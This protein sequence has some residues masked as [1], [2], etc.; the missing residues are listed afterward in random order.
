MT[1]LSAPQTKA[2]V[3]LNVV[4]RVYG[5]FDLWIE[6]IRPTSQLTDQKL[7]SSKVN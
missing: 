5:F 4:I 6:S 2:I 7:L 1:A 3:A